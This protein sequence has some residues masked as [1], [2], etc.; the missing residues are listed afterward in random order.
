MRRR[1][2]EAANLNPLPNVQRA[3][4]ARRGAR[5]KLTS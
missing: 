4:D 3:W 2:N 5:P 1:R